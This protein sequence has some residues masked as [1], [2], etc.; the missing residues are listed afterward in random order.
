MNALL[1]DILMKEIMIVQYANTN[2]SNVQD[3][4]QT[5]LNV[6]LLDGTCQ[7]VLVNTV[8]SKTI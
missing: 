2:A 7:I 8:I 3:R 1:M 6:I 4:V 5:V